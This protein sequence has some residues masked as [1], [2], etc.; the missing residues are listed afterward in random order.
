M[1]SN[2]IKVPECDYGYI[3]ICYSIVPPSLIVLSHVSFSLFVDTLSLHFVWCFFNPD[4]VLYVLLQIAHL[5]DCVGSLVSSITLFGVC[6]D[7]WVLDKLLFKLSYVFGPWLGSFWRKISN[8]H[9]HYGWFLI[10]L[11]WPY[12][13]RHLSKQHY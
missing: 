1:L 2:E 3:V 8:C 11:W 12:P 4:I 5:L 9:L 10:Y 7:D 13:N 6:N